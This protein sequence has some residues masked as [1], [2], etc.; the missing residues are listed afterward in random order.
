M[1]LR[2][3]ILGT[4]LVLAGVAMAIITVLAGRSGDMG[5]TNV[6]AIASLVIAA[7]LLVLVV[8]PLTRSARAEVL[9]MD[10]PFEVTSARVIFLEILLVAGFPARN[11][12]N[13]LFFLSFSALSSTPIASSLSTRSTL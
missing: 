10:L 5:V 2:N 12:G 3:V 13:N 1:K 9:R 8:P 4:L 7:L 11:T 6:A